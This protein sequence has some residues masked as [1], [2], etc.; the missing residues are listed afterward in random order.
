[1]GALPGASLHP[2]LLRM[3]RPPTPRQQTAS[4]GRCCGCWGGGASSGAAAGRGA[5]GEGG[6]A[7]GQARSNE[8]QLARY[9]G[10]GIVGE[11]DFFTHSRR[12]FCARAA[13]RTVAA[14]LTQ[15]QLRRMQAEQPQL[16]VALQA[17]VLRSL[18]LTVSN[19]LANGTL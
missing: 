4:G 11:L 19:N 15:Q 16:A 9:S 13:R 10:G 2:Q 17:A 18:C 3:A 6:Q 14:V 5:A 12:S 8:R 7:G 1:M